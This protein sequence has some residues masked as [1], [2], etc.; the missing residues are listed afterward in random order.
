[1]VEIS[2]VIPTYNRADLLPRAIGSVLNQTFDDFEL[3]VVD[4]GSTD[5]THDVI[6]EFIR[7]DQRIRYFRRENS[8]SPAAPRNVGIE[9]ATG[10]Y[11]AF[12]DHDDEWL[13]T[14][15]ERQSSFFSRAP[16]NI[17]F[18]G[19][20]IVIVDDDTGKELRVHNLS[21]FMGDGFVRGVLRYNFV[22]TASAV[23]VRKEVFDKVGTFDCSLKVG[24]DFDMWLRISDRFGFDFAAEALVKY[25]IHE[26]NASHSQDFAEA[27]FELEKIFIKHRNKYAQ[28]PDI[29]HRT[30]R[31]LGSKFCAL[32][33]TERGRSYYIES[34][35]SGGG[36]AKMRLLYLSSFVL[37]KGIY[38][39]VQNLKKNSS[40][41]TEI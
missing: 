28:Y 2:V 17:G 24:D 14:K 29:Y 6:Q 26:G 30:L 9:Q 40:D 5:H 18:I 12:L 16:S 25:Y 27:T 36:T 8:G 37:G 39:F 32:G 11:I 22:L 3:I 35:R 7:A 10:R 1:M 4:D 23:M 15:L 21:T 20:N 33:E 31:Q 38:N 41:I 19:C 13:P 34:I